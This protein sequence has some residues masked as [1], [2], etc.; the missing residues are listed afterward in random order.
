[1][2]ISQLFEPFYSLSLPEHII[3]LSLTAVV[4][5]VLIGVGK[6]MLLMLAEANAAQALDPDEEGV[7][8]SREIEREAQRRYRSYVVAI[9]KAPIFPFV[10]LVILIH[11]VRR[12][13]Q[14]QFVWHV[15]RSVRQFWAY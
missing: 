10:L 12:R 9:K 5:S 14:S 4:L 7:V 1:M 6:S 3:A 11:A 2:N 15:F 8:S 13:G